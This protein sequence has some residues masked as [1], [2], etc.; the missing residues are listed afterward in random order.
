MTEPIISIKDVSKT[1]ASGLQ[2]LKPINLDIAKGEIFAL[3]GPNGAGS[4]TT[5]RRGARSGW[6]RR[7]CTQM[8]SS[9]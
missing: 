5:S 7:S 3:L 8:L 9:A 2:A 4:A 1:Y 6:C